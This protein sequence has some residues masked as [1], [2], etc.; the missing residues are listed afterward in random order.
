MGLKA[1]L[2][3]PTLDDVCEDYVALRIISPAYA[4]REG[5]LTAILQYVYQSILLDGLNMPSAAKALGE[6]AATEMHH[7]QIL[8][9]LIRNLGA[10]PVFT[11]CPPYPVGYYSSSCVNY[12]KSPKAMIAVDLCA[13][14]NAVSGYESMIKRLQNDKVK[15]VLR[16]IV[17]DEEVH[18]SALEE[19]QKSV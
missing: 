6:I 15:E 3:Y 4:G 7:L 12:T 13:E 16:R 5:E 8:G 10:P 2:P 19:L 11:N 9:S 17:L 14:K 1:D 18:I